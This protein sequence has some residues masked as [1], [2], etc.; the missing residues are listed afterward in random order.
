MKLSPG[1]QVAIGVGVVA[2]GYFLFKQYAPGAP[3][4]ASLPGYQAPGVL[5]AA[6]P[7]QVS[8]ASQYNSLPMSQPALG[9]DQQPVQ[10]VDQ[11]QAPGQ[12]TAQASQLL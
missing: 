4:A 7:G 9:V 6:L 8:P 11:I 2:L 10:P 5:P 12:I 3:T 1:V